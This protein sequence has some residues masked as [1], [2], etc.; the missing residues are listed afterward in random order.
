[1]NLDDQIGLNHL[2]L[3]ERKCKKCGQVKN[4][5][6][7]FYRTKKNRGQVPS[8]YSYECKACCVDR[9]MKQRKNNDEGKWQYPDW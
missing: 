7:G 2:F 5:I 1:M 4:L 3:N 6:D 9:I 8:A